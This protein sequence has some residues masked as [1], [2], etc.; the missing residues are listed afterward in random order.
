[1]QASEGR[2]D[3]I[4][5]EKAYN[6]FARMIEMPVEYIEPVKQELYKAY[7]PLF[8]KAQAQSP[9]EDGKAGVVDV[10]STTE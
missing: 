2:A 6:E 10:A 1:M 8:A 4:A 3:F 7:M 9:V 5:I